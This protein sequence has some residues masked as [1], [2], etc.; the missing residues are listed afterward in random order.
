[1]GAHNSLPNPKIII[2]FYD[3]HK[4]SDE[5]ERNDFMEKGIGKSTK[6]KTKKYKKLKFK[7]H[8]KKNNLIKLIFV[9]FSASLCCLEFSS[10]CFS[11]LYYYI[12]FY[13]L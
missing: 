3:F 11:K 6:G 9:E 2:N 13:I 1:M 4:S 12:S 10:F 8:K 7:L 5:K